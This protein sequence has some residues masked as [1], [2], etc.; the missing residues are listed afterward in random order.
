M[1]LL[2]RLL[3]ID[4]PSSISG[5]TDWVW[6]AASP[7]PVWV[8]VL[9]ALAGLAAAALNFLPHNVM[10]WKTRTLLAIIRVAG[11][12]LLLLMLC[13]LEARLTFQRELR[14]TVAIL[15][16]TSASMGLQDSGN[17]TRLAAA[18]DFAG[19]PLKALADKADI[20]RY[21]FDWKLDADAGG[22]RSR[23]ADAPDRRHRRRR[24]PRERP[25]RDDRPDRR[26]RHGGQSRRTPRARAGRA[27]A[28][29]VPGRLRL[30]GRA[31]ARA[32]EDHE[33]RR[34]RAPRR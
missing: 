17:Q 9:L 22:D 19:G 18:R 1:S 14:P 29:G 12:A 16:D 10:T 33:R 15:T 5:V 27:P 24:A 4:S 25:A 2:L 31:E 26:Q 28:A 34:L 8:I 3:G 30:R 23:A 32:G 7:L 13:Q 6:R 20:V 21:S 11:F